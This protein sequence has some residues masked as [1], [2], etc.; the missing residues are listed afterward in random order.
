MV[1]LDSRSI[2]QIVLVVLLII[3][4][5]SAVYHIRRCDEDDHEMRHKMTI[6]HGAIGIAL[7][8]GVIYV[9]NASL[10]SSTG[11]SE[12]R[13][14]YGIFDRKKKKGPEPAQ[15][16]TSLGNPMKQQTFLDPRRS[17]N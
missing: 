6:M 4:F 2:L 10:A 8:L 15:R 1:K 12:R 3:V 13:S 17:R 5:L 9:T 14:E 16:M 7:A 11:S